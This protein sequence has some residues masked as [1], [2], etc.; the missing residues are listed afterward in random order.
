MSAAEKVVIALGSNLGDREELINL[1]IAAIGK[2]VE[3]TRVSS[4][5]ETDQSVDRNKVAISTEY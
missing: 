4:L 2:D 3:I 1:A 5:I